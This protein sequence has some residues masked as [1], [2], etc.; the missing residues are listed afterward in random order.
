MPKKRSRRDKLDALSLV[1]AGHTRAHVA[2]LTYVSVSTIQRSKRKQKL[3]LTLFST[4]FR[5]EFWIQPCL[6]PRKAS[7][8][9]EVGG[10]PIKSKK[11]RL[12]Q[13]IRSASGAGRNLAD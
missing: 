5:T 1:A 12:S 13:V 9:S 7:A 8:S 11:T 6:S 4:G 2:R 3:P 10:N